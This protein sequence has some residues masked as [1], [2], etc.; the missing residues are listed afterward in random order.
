LTA[1]WKNLLRLNDAVNPSMLEPY[2]PPGTELDS[3]AGGTD[4]SLVGLE[5]NRIRGF[6]VGVPFHRSFEQ[7]NLRF[8][9]QRGA[10]RG[11]VFIGEL[12]PK[13]AVAMMARSVYG[14]NSSCV[15]ISPRTE[16]DQQI[17][18]VRVESAWGSG[19]PRRVARVQTY[20]ESFLP[21]EGSLEPS[22]TKHYWATYGNRMA[23]AGNIMSTIRDGASGQQRARSFAAKRGVLWEAVGSS[24]HR[25]FTS[26]RTRHGWPKALW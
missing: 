23:G 11:V 5:F 16:A 25:C 8:Y 2:V 22:I 19:E 10:R 6:G 20:G 26:P 18:V 3:W 21:T 24:L 12:V 9:G 13:R 7:I 14:E 4:I 15:P 17:G 1:E